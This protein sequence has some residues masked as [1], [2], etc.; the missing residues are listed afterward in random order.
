[1]EQLVFLVELEESAQLVTTA[2]SRHRHRMR[3]GTER[4][5]QRQAE[6]TRLDVCHAP[7]EVTATDQH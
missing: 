6:L 5:T 3:A 4:T 2:R 1:M 7:Q